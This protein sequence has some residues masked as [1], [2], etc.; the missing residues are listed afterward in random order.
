MYFNCEIKFCL[1]IKLRH[2]QILLALI[3]KYSKFYSRG[4]TFTFNKYDTHI[5]N[6]YA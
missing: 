2:K 4:H 1:N 6:Q 3:V 5:T